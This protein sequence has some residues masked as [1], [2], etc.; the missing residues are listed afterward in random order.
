MRYCWGMDA[1]WL[2]ATILH[3]PQ[4]AK[5]YDRGRGGMIV[6]SQW[7]TGVVFSAHPTISFFSVCRMTKQSWARL[8]CTLF[9]EEGGKFYRSNRC[10]ASRASKPSDRGVAFSQQSMGNLRQKACQQW[11]NHTT[12]SSFLPITFVPSALAFSVG[13]ASGIRLP[14]LENC[15]HL[16]N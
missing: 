2:V 10:C 7:E 13:A 5:T 16:S 12:T 8:S 15:Q 3:S 14:K 1:S 9:Y 6:Q 4:D 11:K